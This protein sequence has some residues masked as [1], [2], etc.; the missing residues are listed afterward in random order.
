MDAE[1]DACPGDARLGDAK[2]FLAIL[3]LSL[4]N[5]VQPQSKD[6]TK[7]QEKVNEK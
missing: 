5:T 2:G 3:F 1:S 4:A 6:A 7:G